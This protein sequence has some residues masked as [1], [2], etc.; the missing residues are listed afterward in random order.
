[1]NASRPVAL[2]PAITRC[3]A[4]FVRA[5]ISSAQPTDHGPTQLAY[6]TN[7]FAADDGPS[8]RTRRADRVRLRPMLLP[9]HERDCTS[10]AIIKVDGTTAVGCIP[11]TNS[12]EITTLTL[13]CSANNLQHNV[14]KNMDAIE[15]A[16]LLPAVV[17]MEIR[18]LINF[19]RCTID[20]ML[21]GNTRA[22]YRSCT[23]LRAHHQA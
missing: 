19:Y 6:R 4:R 9:L 14:S 23:I 15:T 22:W 13:C 16:A 1:M 2:T 3:F 5:P 18:I 20:G 8:P 17:C 10:N 21:A 7:R 12:E 11:V